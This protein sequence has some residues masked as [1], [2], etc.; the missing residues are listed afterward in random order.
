MKL[1]ILGVQFH[2]VLGLTCGPILARK[3]YFKLY[4]YYVVRP[5]DSVIKAKIGFSIAGECIA[6]LM[7]RSVTLTPKLLNK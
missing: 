5:K 3:Y 4:L 1:E 2:L 6:S 7:A